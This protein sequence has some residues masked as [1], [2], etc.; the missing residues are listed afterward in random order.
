MPARLDSVEINFHP[1]TASR[2]QELSQQT[3]RT[4]N[5]LIE[6]AMAGYL[7]VLSE[8][9]QLLDARYDDLK[10][11]RVQAIDGDAAFAEL[12]RKSE[13]QRPRS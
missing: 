11:G 7:K 5:E 1:E 8:T 9:R 10:E 12:R 6:D 4:P 2:L 3:G 13:R